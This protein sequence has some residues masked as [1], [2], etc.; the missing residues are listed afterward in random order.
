MLLFR[1]MESWMLFSIKMGD[2]YVYYFGEVQDFS[3]DANGKEY[4]KAFTF[5][6]EGDATTTSWYLTRVVAPNGREVEFRYLE[7]P[8]QLDPYLNPHT[9]M[10]AYS[11]WMNNIN[12]EPHYTHQGSNDQGWVF[13]RVRIFPV[14]LHEIRIDNRISVRYVY[15]QHKEDYSVASM[16][17]TDLQSGRLLK[18]CEFSY[19]YKHEN[20]LRFLQTVKISGEGT[21]NFDYY[22]QDSLIPYQSFYIDHWGYYRGKSNYSSLFQSWKMMVFQGEKIVG[23]KPGS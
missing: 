14:R 23:E 15:N 2:G 6:G 17:V 22:A 8:F 7:A 4:T 12:W 21:Y 10:Y 13:E 9:E 11:D 5:E 3:D 1:I 20:I 16:S 19:L 18:S